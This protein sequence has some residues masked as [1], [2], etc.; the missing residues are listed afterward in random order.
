MKKK[1]HY[2]LLALL[3]TIGGITIAYNKGHISLSGGN[4]VSIITPE[5]GTDVY[6]DDRK[7]GESTESNDTI[8]R[9][10]VDGLHTII[11]AREG[12]WPWSK[13]VEITG[14]TTFSPFLLPVRV[15]WDRITL[16]SPQY[17][18]IAPL[19]KNTPAPTASSPLQSPN[20]T[21]SVWIEGTEIMA[22]WIGI[23][24]AAPTYFCENSCTGPRSILSSAKP[25]HNLFF[26]KDRNDILVF[27][28]DD[29]VYAIELDTRGTQNFQPIFS[30]RSVRF[31]KQDADR[32][33]V[34]DEE[35]LYRVDI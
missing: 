16:V 26:F 27:S 24:D 23:D 3:I 33:Y 30:G 5:E 29:G 9:N 17:A 35:K 11:V 18:E 22:Q 34:L 12:T 19:V 20:N 15:E 7:V 6:I 8:K 13:E 2:I 31:Y 14:S 32:M 4:T 10:V 1:T 25:V 21:V 28:I